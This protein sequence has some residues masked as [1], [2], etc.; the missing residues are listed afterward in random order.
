MRIVTLKLMIITFT[1]SSKGS[2]LTIII[3]M[4]VVISVGVIIMFINVPVC[5]YIK[6]CLRNSNRPNITTN[7]D[8]SDNSNK[9]KIIT[10]II[11]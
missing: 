8:T 9:G 4:I 11:L 2:L 6:L 1:D 3:V 7:N 5:L 10:S